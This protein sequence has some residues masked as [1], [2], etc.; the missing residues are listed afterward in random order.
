MMVNWPKSLPDYKWPDRYTST[1]MAAVRTAMAGIFYIGYAIGLLMHWLRPTENTV[2]VLRTDGM[3]D[4]LL[5]E[6]ALESIARA[7]SPHVVHLWAPKL[8][9]QLLAPCPSA[10]RIMQIPRGFKDG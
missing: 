10:N 7:V 3:G 4:G 9:C 1:G 5:F 6:P 2:L 8:T